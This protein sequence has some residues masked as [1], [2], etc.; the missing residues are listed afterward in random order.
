M[1][2]LLLENPGPLFLVALCCAFLLLRAG[3]G[4]MSEHLVALSI[5]CG[6]AS[7][8]LYV[9]LIA[10]DVSRVGMLWHDEAN[11][12][13][14]AAAYSRGLPIYHPVASDSFYSLFYGPSTFL[15]YAPFLTIFP[16]PILALRI[17]V[18]VVS[19]ADVVLLYV[20]MRR[21]VKP[22]TALALLPV[23]LAFLLAYPGVLF[24]DRGDVWLLFCVALALLIAVRS[25]VRFWWVASLGC[26]IMAGLALDFKVTAL[27]VA[28]VLA[29]VLY[30]RF[31]FKAVGSGVL[32]C[33][34]AAFAIFALP[35]VSLAN[36]VAWLVVS[37]H[38]RF[39]RSTC[40]GNLIA[41]LLL[42]APLVLV[43]RSATRSEKPRRL[44]W[45]IAT[46]AFALIVCVITGSKDGAGGW[47]LWPLVPVFLGAAA[48]AASLR[49]EGNVDRSSVVGAARG[50]V[51]SNTL[52]ALASLAVAGMVSTAY[53]AAKDYRVVRPRGDREF[54][55]R[56]EVAQSELEGLSRRSFAG[57]SLTM[58]YGAAVT[59]YRTDL[60]YELVLANR[61][62]FFDENSVVEGI[63]AG[64]TVPERVTER[65]LGCQDVWVIPHDEA[66][67]SSVRFGVLPVTASPYIFSDE[68]RLGFAKTHV[69]FEQG[70]VYDLWTCGSNVPAR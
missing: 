41:A 60:R 14:I 2:H 25:Q 47:H 30:R 43:F 70:A 48:Y 52:I 56:E 17:G 15:A 42:V 22:S 61:G 18:F 62:Y 49:G 6:V 37:G 55:V 10:L 32:A 69:R 54:R 21:W 13:S 45:I 24:A 68:I 66:P 51:A 26:G 27:P 53:F 9:L 59:D 20:L 34:F 28:C 19:L 29:A 11:I 64:F 44:G 50:I 35:R 1:A 65:I 38:Q 40:L 36:Y 4:W 63:K 39:L 12:L 16:N 58:G 31:G 5:W 67:F 3:K 46:T 33:L 7:A 8:S 23:G 57:Q